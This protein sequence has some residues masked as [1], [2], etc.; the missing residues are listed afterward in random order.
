[1][2]EQRDPLLTVAAHR[3]ILGKRLDQLSDA[4][5]DLEREVWCRRPDEGLDVVDRRLR[6]G[7]QSVTSSVGTM[8]RPHV[9]EVMLLATIGL[10]ALNLTLSRYVLTNGLLPLAYS[11]VRYGSAAL[12]F[13]GLALG[14]ERSLRIPRSEWRWVGVAALAL[15][16]NQIVFVYALRETTAST[17]ALVLGATPIFAALFG[18]LLGTERPSQRFWLGAALSFAGVGLV[19]LG[20]GGEVSGDLG[21]ILLAVLTAATWAVY[22]IAITPL[23]RHSSPIRISAVVLP[24]AWIGIVAVGLPQILDEDWGALGWEVWGIVVLATLGPLV[25]TNLLWFR[26]LDRI[27]PSRA[28]LATNLQ[29]FVAAVFAVVL[30]SERITWIQGVGGLLVG[31]GILVARRR[32]LVAPD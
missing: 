14:W 17:V 32:A 6:H 24:L 28:T 21:G 12:I 9:V 3:V 7:G 19:A 23:M 5:S 29:P 13:V 2:I 18:L 1:M 27:G 31:L 26:V 15:W 22:S 30:L 20:T 8:R 25:V 4:S 16:V 11:A 10:W